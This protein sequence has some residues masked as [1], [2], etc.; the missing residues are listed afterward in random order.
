MGNITITPLYIST[1]IKNKII[2]TYR[3]LFPPIISE[4]TNGYIFRFG[5]RNKIDDSYLF[6]LKFLLLLPIMPYTLF[7]SFILRNTCK[8]FVNDIFSI[9]IGQYPHVYNIYSQNI[10]KNLVC[11]CCSDTHNRHN[12]LGTLPPG[13]ILIHSGDAT[14]FGTVE[15]LS[16]FATWM[17]SQPHKYKFYV[18]GNHDCSLDEEFSSKY[19]SDFEDSLPDFL[20]VRKMFEAEGISVLMD[21]G[22]EVEGLK[23][24]GTPWIPKEYSWRTA[25]NR[26]EEELLE[27]WGSIPPSDVL[28]SHSPAYGLV[29]MTGTGKC[30]GSKSLRTHIQNRV[31]PIL[32]VCGHIHTDSGG[33]TCA[34][35]DTHTHTHGHTHTDNGVYYNACLHVNAAC[36]SE[37]YRV[38][39]PLVVKIT[40]LD[41]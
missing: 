16:Q 40:K 11:V 27:V 5:W 41:T 8:K 18:P 10:H 20:S 38:R 34:H 23:V 35:T 4:C 24:W 13:D 32:H 36:V 3:I 22:E 39:R 37:V 7:K 28:I 14:C 31:K 17:G 9:E 30:K 12:L 1:Y 19:W 15:E 29:D 25:F 6:R 2:I 21:S 33:V 26:T